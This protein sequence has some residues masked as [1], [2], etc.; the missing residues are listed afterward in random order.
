[1]LNVMNFT[2]SNSR[3]ESLYH[4][5]NEFKN[6]KE[7]VLELLEEYPADWILELVDESLKDDEEIILKAIEESGEGLEYASERLK[8]N[9][10]FILKVIDLAPWEFKNVPPALRRDIDVV[11]LAYDTYD[12]NEI[13]QYLDKDIKEK[14][15]Q[16]ESIY[17]VER[18]NP[19][20]F[21]KKLF[22]KLL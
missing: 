21:L 19:K 17:E 6:N 7:K 13:W 2:T 10:D 12:D 11:L 14:V 20:K 8:N 4:I 3:K 9:K 1:M 15:L 22:M 16:I 5:R 18:V